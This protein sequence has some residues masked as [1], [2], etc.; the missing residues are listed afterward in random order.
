MKNKLPVNAKKVFEGKIF[1]VY[2]WEQKMF[3]GSVEVFERLKRPDTECVIAI[4]GDKIIIQY[5]EQPDSGPFLSLPGGRN[6]QNEEDVVAAKRELLEETG[7]SSEDIVL[8]KKISP[9]SKMEWSVNY[10][11]AR[12]CKK[13]QEPKLDSGEKIENKLV[14]Y[15]EFLMLSEDETFRERELLAIL[16][17]IHFNLEKMEEFKTFLF[18]K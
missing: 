8:W 1:D 3:D 12:N 14:S 13:I 5:Q 7:Y 4:V 16:L 2:Q 11:V 15:E 18:G 9:V 10:F 6:D 17:R